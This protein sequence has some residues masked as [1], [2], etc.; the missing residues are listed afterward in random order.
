MALWFVFI[1]FNCEYPLTPCI[2]RRE[3]L[4]CQRDEVVGVPRLHEAGLSLSL[5]Q[6]SGPTGFHP[7]R[8]VRIQ[9]QPHFVQ[10][11]WLTCRHRPRHHCPSRKCHPGPGGAAHGSLRD[12]SFPPLPWHRL[13]DRVCPSQWLAQEV[14]EVHLLLLWR[15][16]GGSGRACGHRATR[17]EGAMACRPLILGLV[18]LPPRHR[19]PGLL[20]PHKL[21]E[22]TVL[23]GTPPHGEGEGWS[24]HCCQAL[25]LGR[26]FV[27]P[28][29]NG[30]PRLPGRVLTT[31]E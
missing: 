29:T 30:F 18:V 26:R 22:A 4:S 6:S 23:L 17:W 7:L 13:G 12:L 9:P 27:A 28:V 1:V 14:T 8:K 3:K 24:C 2:E 10:P 20:S 5:R 15:S 31:R 11:P 21:L 19:G 16:L 25:A